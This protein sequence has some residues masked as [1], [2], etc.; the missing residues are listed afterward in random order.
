LA[1]TIR[2]DNTHTTIEP[3]EDFGGLEWYSHDASTYG[4]GIS[5][6]IRNTA[7]NAG[8]SSALTFGVRPSSG[9]D[10]AL[11]KMRID[12]NGLEVY[13]NVN[14]DGNILATGTVTGTNLALQQER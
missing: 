4:T 12:P 8:V 9:T 7:V 1:P 2:I 10:D 6:F 11:E 5:G 3:D 14:I 13:G